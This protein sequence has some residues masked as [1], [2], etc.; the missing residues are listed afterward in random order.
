MRINYSWHQITFTSWRTCRSLPGIS[1]L[2]LPSSILNRKSHRIL[3]TSLPEWTLILVS[4]F[5]ETS[6]GPSR[7]QVRRWRK[8]QLLSWPKNAM[9]GGLVSFL[10]HFRATLSYEKVK[11]QLPGWYFSREISN[12]IANL[13]P[14]AIF[15]LI[16]TKWSFSL[17]WLFKWSAVVRESSL[18]CS[19]I[20]KG[21]RWRRFWRRIL[22]CNHFWEKKIDLFRR[23]IRGGKRKGWFCCCLN[24]SDS[25]WNVNTIVDAQFCQRNKVKIYL[26][27]FQF[28]A[29]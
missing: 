22:S 9:D 24:L 18:L 8:K 5:L 20:S 28:M 16:I 12:F 6:S 19:V 17:L 15:E 7:R 29:Q 3:T 10:P 13:V 21:S 27:N 1:L 25:L 26:K 23:R 14:R 4:W 11:V 2:F